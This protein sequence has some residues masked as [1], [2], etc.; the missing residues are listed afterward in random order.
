[1]EQAI[2]KSSPGAAKGPAGRTKQ[3][4]ASG[5]RPGFAPAVAL[6]VIATATIEASLAFRAWVQLSGNQLDNLGLK[7]IYGLS[8]QAVAPFKGLE[9]TTPVRQQGILEL[10]T[11][12]ALEA[13]LLL[14][15]AVVCI[16]FL[17]RKLLP[18]TA[19]RFSQSSKDAQDAAAHPAERTA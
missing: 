9:T 2:V 17:G 7:L 12:V 10:S 19:F 6:I 8:S 18:R 15:V 13:Y 16:L 5:T 4:P 14:A 3:A 11:L 1:M